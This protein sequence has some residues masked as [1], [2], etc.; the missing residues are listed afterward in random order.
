MVGCHF[1]RAR[2]LPVAPPNLFDTLVHE[3]N[4]RLRTYP[5]SESIAVRTF[6]Y[7]II[8]PNALESVERGEMCVAIVLT[9]HLGEV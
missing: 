8:G 4:A 5:A 1:Y 6:D 7:P 2:P 3:P 9:F